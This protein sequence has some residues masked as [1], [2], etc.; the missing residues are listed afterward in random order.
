[1]LKISIKVRHDAIKAAKEADVVSAKFDADEKAQ[2]ETLI[3]VF[4]SRGLGQL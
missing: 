1:M 2:K 3:E 4:Q